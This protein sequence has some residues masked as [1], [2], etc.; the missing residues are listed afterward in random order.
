MFRYRIGRCREHGAPGPT[1]GRTPYDSS[2]ERA[3]SRS[4]DGTRIVDHGTMSRQYLRFA[5]FEDAASKQEGGPGAGD[6]PSD[7]NARQRQTQR[8]VARLRDPFG[9][10]L[11][12]AMRCSQTEP[13]CMVRRRSTVRFRNGAPEKDQVRSSP[14]SSHS[15][16][17]MGAVAVLGGIWEI[18]SSQSSRAEKAGPV[19][20][21][22]VR[23]RDAGPG[24]R[25][26][27]PGT[28]LAAY[29]TA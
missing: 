28:A 26:V 18:V 20:P 16:R 22:R 5:R 21:A 2:A 27:W 17:R 6:K 14:N 9:L 24:D 11:S 7:Y 19:G 10:R 1:A 23:R 8:D 15:T 3:G 4:G 12:D 13:P 25:S 29:P